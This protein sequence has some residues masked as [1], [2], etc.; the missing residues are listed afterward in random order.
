M[1]NFD[2]KINELDERQRAVNEEALKRYREQK[3]EIEASIGVLSA[4]SQD[5]SRLKEALRVI[6]GHI[7]STLTDLGQNV[8]KK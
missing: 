6:D 5:T 2:H 7:N 3:R 1:N 4:Q 8:N